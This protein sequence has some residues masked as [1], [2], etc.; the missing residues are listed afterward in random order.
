MF[1]L[2][3]PDD[4]DPETYVDALAQADLKLEYAN[5]VLAL[6]RIRMV[7]NALQPRALR[8]ARLSDGGLPSMA[9]R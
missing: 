1:F 7:K 5:E 4:Y 9:R 8:A 2:R 6:H 3:R